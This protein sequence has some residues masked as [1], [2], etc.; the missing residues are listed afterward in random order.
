MR[1]IRKRILDDLGAVWTVHNF[2]VSHYDSSSWK[3]DVT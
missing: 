1:L 2:V 3:T